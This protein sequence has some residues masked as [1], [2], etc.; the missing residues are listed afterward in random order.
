MAIKMISTNGQIQYNV[1]EFV[2]DTPEERK[3]LPRKSV[4]GSIALC[5][6]TSDVYIKNG[7]GEWVLLGDSSGGGGGGGGTGADGKSAYE[8]AVEHGFSGTEEEWLESLKGE[9]PYIGVNGNWFI[10]DVD[11]GISASSTNDYNDLINKPTLNGDDIQ[12]EVTIPTIATEDID[13]LFPQ[14]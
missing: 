12:G 1:D 6:S 10:G 5:L 8:I 14:P 9:S 7:K 2:I 13:A 11:T 4:M 3:S